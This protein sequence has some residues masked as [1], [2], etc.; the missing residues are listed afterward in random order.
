MQVDGVQ[1]GHDQDASQ[2]PVHIEPGI[3][4][5]GDCACD[6][7]RQKSRAK[8]QGRIPPAD[9]QHRGNCRARGEAAVDRDVG[10]IMNA[11]G[12]EHPHGHEGI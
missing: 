9:E 10:E 12:E 4:I 5:G 3:D 6:A 2:Q 1:A 7:A 11:E 8:G